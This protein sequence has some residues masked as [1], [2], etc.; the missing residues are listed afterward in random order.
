MARRRDKTV[1]VLVRPGK[2]IGTGT[3]A[4]WL[5]RLVP[6]AVLLVAPVVPPAGAEVVA[7]EADEVSGPLTLA[8]AIVRHLGSRLG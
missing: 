3:I 1:V 5:R 7:I 4:S 6:A 2:K 8:D